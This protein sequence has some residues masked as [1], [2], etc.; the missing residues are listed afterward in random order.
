MS[1][2][3]TLNYDSEELS[4]ETEFNDLYSPEFK[5]EFYTKDESYPIGLTKYEATVLMNMLKDI[6]ED[7]RTRD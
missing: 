3:K 7:E 4:I 2:S 1:Y 6:L 5:V